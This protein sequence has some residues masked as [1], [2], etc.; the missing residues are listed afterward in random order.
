[1][2]KQKLDASSNIA[3]AAILHDLGKMA[4][5]GKIPTSKETL[6]NNKH[7]YC[8]F[9]R[10]GGW[11]SHVHAAYSA[12]GIDLIEPWLPDLKKAKAYPFGGWSDE[13]AEGLDDSL[14][15][16]AAKHHRPDTALQWIVAAADRLASGFEREEFADYNKAKE[17]PETGRNHYQARQLSLY[18]QIDAADESKTPSVGDLK[19]RY[20]LA[21]MSAE[22]IFPVLAS[23]YEPSDDATAQAEYLALWDGFVDGLKKIPEHHRENLALWL[24]HFDSLYLNYCHA[25]PSATAF[26]T[27]PDVSLYDHSKAVAALA[28]ALW[29]YYDEGG[30]SGDDIVT[31]L[32]SGKDR[33]EQKF[34]MVQGD[35]TGIQDFIFSS[36]S[37]T[38]KRAAKTL[39]GRSLYVSLLTECGAIRVLEGLSLPSTSQ[40]VNAAGKF[41]I[42]A[43]NTPETLSALEA[44]QEEFDAWFLE[45]TYGV[46]GLV[47]ASTPA[48]SRDF[49]RGGDD[50]R[51][52]FSNLMERLFEHLEARKLS[53]FN[54]CETSEP[55][56]ILSDFLENLD[57]DKGLCALNNRYPATRELEDGVYISDISHDQVKFGEYVI[58]TDHLVVARSAITDHTN[59]V[60]IFGYVLNFMDRKQAA[61]EHP[62]VAD[63]DVIRVYDFSLP[64]DGETPLW[65]G[66]SRRHVSA[67]VPRFD[68]SD[69]GLSD[70][71][72]VLTENEDQTPK[73][74]DLK[75]FGHLAC[76]DRYLDENGNWLGIG[77]LSVVKGDIDDLSM[78]FQGGLRKP[79]FAK[80]AG[81]SRQLNAFFTIH[82]PHFCAVHHPNTYTVFAGG[83]D[84]FM[85]GPWKSQM[86]LLQDMRESFARFTVNPAIHFSAGISTLK[87]GVPIQS[88][89][90]TAEA[91]LEAAK[92]H[93]PTKNAVTCYGS[94]VEWPHWSKLTGLAEKMDRLQREYG[95]STGYL[96]GLIGLTELAAKVDENPENAIWLSRF[97]YR[98]KRFVDD[99][100]RGADDA[101]KEQAVSDLLTLAEGIKQHGGAFNIP[102]FNHLYTYR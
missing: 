92:T 1:M 62:G 61:K 76:E 93:A 40:I 57:S 81:L 85:V 33:E 48:S 71:Y 68:E 97:V 22:N 72:G 9:H 45:H 47:L 55:R 39:R 100:M 36:G 24:D 91:A 86:R 30:V 23:A 10:D 66:Y 94:T 80:M 69:E 4:E 73:A 41:L 70:R 6:E 31:N 83:D 5:R 51:S 43:P 52:P 64:V 28:V 77:A 101:R 54:L 17:K 8:P 63:G 82:L 44:L 84:F 98:S 59:S 102:L 25:I 95:L 18:E 79:T 99:N 90:R 12:I 19:Y 13:G 50:G 67:Y 38:N 14:I 49:M 27:R 78:I 96:Y 58:Q 89:A 29:R 65:N 35:F 56:L 3:L 11:F 16:G 26:G 53:R 21:P 75:T 60:P 46:S 87:P 32:K 42:V 2:N 88:M 37:E 20:K 15:N 74:G 7:L 34:L